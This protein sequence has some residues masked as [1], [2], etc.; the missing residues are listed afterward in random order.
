MRI[1]ESSKRSLWLIVIVMAIAAA[2]AYLL[3][4]A[5]IG[6]SNDDWY[7]MYDAHVAGT[8]IF[9]EI[10]SIDR[11][12]RAYLQIPLYILFGES[13]LPY[14]I[15]SYFFR[16]LGALA[17]FW[18][19]D[20]TW[21]NKRKEMFSVALLFLLYPGFISQVTPIDFQAH[22][23]SLCMGMLSIAFT[24]KA[25]TTSQRAPKIAFIA[26]SLLFGIIYPSIMEYFIGLEVFRLALIALFILRGQNTNLIQRAITILKTWLPF[27]ISPLAF[28]FWHT[29]IFQN[30]RRATD[31]GAQ[32]GKVF[33]S[34][35]YMALQW[36]IALLQDTFKVIFLAWAVPLYDMVFQL[37]LRDMLLGLVLAVLTG[38]IVAWAS[39]VIGREQEKP[40][41]KQDWQKE[42][43]WVGLAGVLG[44]LLPVILANR[45]ADFGGYS[46]YT[47]TASA[48]GVL[49]V[50]A[51]LDYLKSTRLR[52]AAISLLAGIAIL[53]HYANARNALDISDALRNFWWQV[54]WRAPQFKDNTTLAINYA[55][56]GVAEDYFVW[57]PANFI[58][59]PQP[60]NTIPVWARI[61]GIVLTQD[62]ILRVVDERGQNTS[63]GRGYYSDQSFNNVT[64]IAQ[65][66]PDSCIRILNGSS[67]DLSSQDL[68]GMM[69]MAPHSKINN[70]ITDGKSPTP[71]STVFGN[72]PPHG[73]CYFYEKADL[74]RQQ[75]NWQEVDKLGNEALSQG[76]YPSDSIEWMPFLQADLIL[77]KNDQAHKLVPIMGADPFLK[78][79]TCQT[80]THMKDASFNTYTQNFIQQSFCQ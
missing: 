43:L 22:I 5:K 17:L 47:L 64:V 61:S 8:Q 66:T 62:N 79:E 50:I 6:Y 46:R 13:A 24:V 18:A 19:L 36:S 74:A 21:P 67:P 16:L 45:Q 39:F 34:P 11:P 30:E 25:V 49:I 44:G 15:N 58:Y 56:G 69:L 52:T 48:G 70:V 60:Q 73:C 32:I 77:G 2:V 53:T 20:M 57:G 75:G 3:F 37:R 71:P 40:D 28:L 4:A 1:F 65:T 68:Q 51:L 59:S 55:K 78:A 27:S 42:A 14:F 38:I 12:A 76:F 72:E 31:V 54:S 29:F 35:F 63:R 80:L 9:H 23:F 7:L 26:L 41:T 10:F 33:T